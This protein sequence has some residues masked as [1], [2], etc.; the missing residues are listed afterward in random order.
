MKTGNF[1]F[2][3]SGLP[4]KPAFVDGV[5]ESDA[6]DAKRGCQQERAIVPDE[7][8]EVSQSTDEVDT[9]TGLAYDEASDWVAEECSNA[10][11]EVYEAVY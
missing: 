4:R 10:A 1:S 11:N 5:E 7:F 6:N 3:P 2:T 9:G 8:L